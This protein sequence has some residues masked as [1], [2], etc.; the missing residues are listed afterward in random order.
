MQ[1]SKRALSL[2]EG[3]THS[4]LFSADWQLGS[5]NCDEQRITKDLEL[6]R[7]RGSDIILVGDIFD[8]IFPTDRRY[9]PSCVAKWLRDTDDHAGAALRRARELL[10][11]VARQV[12]LVAGGNH[13][14]HVI[15][16]HSVDLTKGLCERLPNAVPGGY[17]GYVT[18]RAAGVQPYVIHYDHGSG[19]DSQNKGILNATRKS[20]HHTFDMY[21]TGHL[22]NRWCVDDVAIV[23]GKVRP[24]KL[25]MV[26]SYLKSQNG[27]PASS[28]YEERWGL[29]PKPLGGIFV[30]LTRDGNILTPTVEL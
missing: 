29:S 16:R 17:C 15:E 27:N 23:N 13:E 28:S 21:V 7:K 14:E 6:A 24:R 26:G 4:I 30:T 1:I 5:V 10:E 8:G 19:G 20:M 12:R 3:A 22:H 2:S 11:P 18:Y 9:R 25:L